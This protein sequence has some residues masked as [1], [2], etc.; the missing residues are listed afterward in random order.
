[1]FMLLQLV[2]VV[3]VLVLVVV[4]EQALCLGVGQ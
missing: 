3:V 2:R 4:A 1:L